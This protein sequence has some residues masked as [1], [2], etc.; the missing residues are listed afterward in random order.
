[1]IEYIPLDYDVELN[2]DEIYEKVK[3]KKVGICATVQYLKKAKELKEFLESKGVKVVIGKSASTEEEFQ[4]LGCDVTACKGAEVY[5]YIGD[6]K[7]HP[8][9]IQYKTGKKVLNAISMNFVDESEVQK[10]KNYIK[11]AYLK[12]IQAKRI[13]IIISTKPGQNRL[14]LA[15]S[16]KEKFPDKKFYIFVMN[17]VDPNQLNDYPVDMWINTAC[18]RLIDEREKFLKPIMNVGDLLEMGATFS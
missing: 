15:K 4:V 10:L 5:I 1:M 17:D 14:E 2:F 6:G 11:G 8:I 3:G 18:P 7:F 9:W 13:G 12:F 16:L